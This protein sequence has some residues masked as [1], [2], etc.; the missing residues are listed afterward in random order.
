[1][2][3]HQRDFI[4]KYTHCSEK[5]FWNQVIH[6]PLPPHPW[7][8]CQ[9]ILIWDPIVAFGISTLCPVCACCLESTCSWTSDRKNNFMP[10]KLFHI[11]SNVLLISAIYKCQ[12]CGFVLAHDSRI[13]NVD[14]QQN[15]SP[16]FVLFHDSGYTAEAYDFII[17]LTH[18]GFTNPL[19]NSQHIC[20]IHLFLS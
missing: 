18:E 7:C 15:H 11:G 19:V 20:I 17:N 13:D 1:M 3:A 4:D 16:G 14:T 6:P 8:Q 12:S 9:G 2:N 10:R 5:S